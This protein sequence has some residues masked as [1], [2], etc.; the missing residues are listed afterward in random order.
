MKRAL[1]TATKRAIVTDWMV[2]ERTTKRLRARVAGAMVMA[3]RVLGEGM[4][5]QQRGQWSWQWQQ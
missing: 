1:A 5:K 2:I 4:Q 3:T